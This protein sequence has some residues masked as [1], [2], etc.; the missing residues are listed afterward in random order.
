MKKIIFL[1]LVS[2]NTQ[3]NDLI[4]KHGFE[5]TVLISGTA[6]GLESTGLVLRLQSDTN[7]LIDDSIV[8]NANGGFAFYQLLKIGDIY[9]VSITTLPNSPSHQNCI[10]SNANGTVPNTG[11]DNITIDC[12][13]GAWNWNQMNWNQGGW[14]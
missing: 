7:P 1:L 2:L 10:L 8:I 14:Q 13:S 12:D 6:S 4:Y 11:V 9:T 3:A 5:E